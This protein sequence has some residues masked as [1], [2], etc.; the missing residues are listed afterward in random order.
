M[1]AARVTRLDR[2]RFEVW[3]RVPGIS[4]AV[5]EDSYRFERAAT[6]ADRRQ[7]SPRPVPAPLV[8]EAIAAGV[9]VRRMGDLFGGLL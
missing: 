3:S 2:D 6:A 8:K 7:P 5:L 1:S 9:P 4:L